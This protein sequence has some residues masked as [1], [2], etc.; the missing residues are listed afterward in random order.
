MVAAASKSM[1]RARRFQKATGVPRIYDSYKAMLENEKL[2]A[3]YIATSHNFHADNAR[4]CLE[5]DLPVLIEKPIAQNAKQAEEIIALARR[6][7]LFMMEALW[8]RFTPATTRLLS[9]LNEGVLGSIKTLN[10]D[11]C[12]RMN[13]LSPKMR[14]WNRIYSPR[15][16]GGA[17]LDLGIYPVSY[18][19]MVFGRQPSEVTSSA[20]MTR[21]GV[22]KVS[23]YAFDYPHGARAELKSAFV[24]AGSC[25]ALIA[26][27][28]GSICI[29]H[30]YRAD[31]LILRLDGKPEEVIQCAEPGFEFEIY[32]A[33]RCLREGLTES[34]VMP[35]AESLDTMKILDAIRAQWG[36][37]YPG[38]QT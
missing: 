15:L 35:L 27:S 9:L 18:A 13:P 6:K 11:F 29:P 24:E 12:I 31:R 19:R 10:A 2:D 8:T 16:A 17:L 30:F 32:E 25:D 20:K 3:V 28:K 4:L 26:G 37:K 14:S 1:R 23:Q 38:E 33:H 21:T 5:Y 34:P 22:D 36:M 7:N